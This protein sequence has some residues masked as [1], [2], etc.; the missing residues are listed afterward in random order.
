M[1]DL[2]QHSFVGWSIDRKNEARRVRSIVCYGFVSL[3]LLLLPNILFKS[4]LNTRADNQVTRDM[5][6]RLGKEQ[7]EI[8]QMQ[9][10]FRLD[11]DKRK[12]ATDTEKDLEMETET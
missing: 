3:L 9:D 7:Q 4:F 10:L 12:R 11:K 2:K 8:P 1:S 6:I 5:C